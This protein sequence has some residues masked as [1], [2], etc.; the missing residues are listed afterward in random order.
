[1]HKEEFGKFNKVNLFSYCSSMNMNNAQVISPNG[2][3]VNGHSSNYNA[4]VMGSK[5]SNWTYTTYG[6]RSIDR[7]RVNLVK[8]LI[9]Y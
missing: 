9:L 8:K 2:V 5:Q 4:I 3:T 7:I 1:M 6:C